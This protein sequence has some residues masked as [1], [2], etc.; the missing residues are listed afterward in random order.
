MYYLLCNIVKHKNIIRCKSNTRSGSI[1]GPGQ[2]FFEY[3]QYPKKKPD[4]VELFLE[5]LESQNLDMV[6]LEKMC[7]NQDTVE[8]W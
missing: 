7:E 8:E 5:W 3:N 6:E 1:T 2:I 4:D